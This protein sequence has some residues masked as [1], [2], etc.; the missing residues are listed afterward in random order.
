MVNIACSPS[1]IESA[2]A[3]SSVG[4]SWEKPGTLPTKVGFVSLIEP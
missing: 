3:S 4:Y 1:R 2:I